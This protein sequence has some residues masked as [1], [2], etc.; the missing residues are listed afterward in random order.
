MVDPVRGSHP[1]RATKR[2]ATPINHSRLVFRLESTATGCRWLLA[3]WNELAAILE[4]G[5]CWRSPD[6][7][8][9]IR[10]LGKQP[11]DAIVDRDVLRIFLA[12]HVL[13]PSSKSPF[14]DLLREVGE[15]PGDPDPVL[16]PLLRQLTIEP[17]NPKDSAEA[18][19]VL[20]SLVDRAASRLRILLADHE[21][22]EHEMATGPADRHAF[23]FDHDGELMRRYEMSCDRAFHR[24]VGQLRLLGKDAPA[25]GRD[26]RTAA[27]ETE[28]VDSVSRTTEPAEETGAQSLVSPMLSTVERPLPEAGSG[29]PAPANDHVEPDMGDGQKLRNEAVA[30]FIDRNDLEGKTGDRAEPATGNGREIT[31][32]SRCGFY[33]S[34]RFRRPGGACAPPVRPPKPPECPR[35]G[36]TRPALLVPA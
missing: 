19:Q 30:A 7:F 15:R 21:A 14:Q 24:A 9:A 25:R 13:C 22:R 2:R 28:R 26:T 31:K 8:R 6:R 1:P 4:A 16:R 33:R 11:L 36:N 10:L 20:A 5:D 27:A 35:S 34:S 17:Y 32:R 29:V 3:R 12:C 18:L 23:D